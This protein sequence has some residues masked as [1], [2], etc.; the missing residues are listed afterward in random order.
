MLSYSVGGLDSEGLLTRLHD[1]DGVALGKKVCD[2]PAVRPSE[3]LSAS[4]AGSFSRAAAGR[5]VPLLS[6]WD[7]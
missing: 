5:A 7:S 3:S 2:F 1:V 4:V 6:L